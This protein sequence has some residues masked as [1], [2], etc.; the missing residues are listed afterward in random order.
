MR[1]YFSLVTADYWNAKNKLE[2]AAKELAQEMGRKIIPGD[3][4]PDF[5]Q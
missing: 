5:K 4:I 2:T 1:Q 3:R